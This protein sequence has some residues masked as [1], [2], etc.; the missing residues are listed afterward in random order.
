M[1]GRYLDKIT[2]GDCR[3]HLPSSR[4]AASSRFSP[5]FHTARMSIES[6]KPRNLSAL[7][8]F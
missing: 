6:M 8:R 3:E 7:F 1:N 2:L 4:T 5:I